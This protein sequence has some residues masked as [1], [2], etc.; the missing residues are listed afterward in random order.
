[1]SVSNAKVG[2]K[3]AYLRVCKD[4]TQQQLAAVLDVSH[5]AVSK[6]ENGACLPDIDSMLKLS[7]LFGIT[8]EELLN[9]EIDEEPA[10]IIDSITDSA[11]TA[12]KAGLKFGKSI[13]S[14]VT[15]VFENVT[16][17]FTDK[18][19]EPDEA[20][21]TEET[22][23][24]TTEEKTEESPEA[25]EASEET[26]NE[27]KAHMSLAALL[28]LA[29][30]MGKEKLSEEVLNSEEEIT[31]EMLKQFAPFLTSEAL[32]L[33]IGRLNPEYVNAELITSLAP[34]MKKELLYKLV[35]KNINDF[36]LESLKGVAPFLKKGMLDS[37][38]DA[39]NGVKTAAS[40]VELDAIAEKAQQKAKQLYNKLKD[41]AK[42]QEKPQKPAEPK[43][44][45]KN[46]KD[47]VARAALAAEN[48]AWLSC[49]ISEISDSGLLKDICLHASATLDT[50][51][52]RG[53]ALDAYKRMETGDL[54]EVINAFIAKDDWET[55]ALLC[56]AA[57]SETVKNATLAYLEKGT[58]DAAKAFAAK[59]DDAA[60][61]EITKAALDKG[62]WE[63]IDMLSDLM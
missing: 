46:L 3:I 32:S 62:A 27:E 19:S 43:P 30:F 1:M 23:E 52:A 12:A 45:R 35:L 60:L 47:M 8:I 2:A 36:D 21:K 33:L 59:L 26:P 41:A 24:E 29:P 55:A 42:A 22:T 39:I 56:D 15:K 7:K 44:E 61:E 16:D 34:F 5:Q 58:L 50:I 48:W 14:S 20:P 51:P 25:E 31:P 11:A 18:A 53:I 6:W 54:S 28:E 17:S 37:L 9:G 40:G 57:D 10:T 4:L 13:V 38:I 63:F 49:H